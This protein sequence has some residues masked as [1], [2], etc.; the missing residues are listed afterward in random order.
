MKHLGPISG[1]ATYQDKYV[2]TAGYDNLVILWDGITKMPIDRSYHDH[3]ANQCAFSPDGR[4]LVSA[5]SDYTARLW[6]LP[7]MRLQ[8][9]LIG[10]NDDVEM[11]AF[12]SSGSLIATCSRDHTIRVFGL[13]GVIK[14]I[15]CGHKSDVISVTWQHNS[16]YLISS[17]DDG[18]VRKWNTDNGEL[19]ETIDLNGVE[20]DTVVITQ[21]GIIFAGD[22]EGKISVITGTSLIHTPAHSAGIKKLVYNAAK[23]LLVSL[24]YDR[25]L[26]IWSVNSGACLTKVCTAK[27]P[28]II[29]PRSCDF[30]SE[31]K[32]VLGTFGST[33]A[34]YDYG[35]NVWNIEGIEPDISLN[36]VAYVNNKTYAVGDAGIVFCNG[37]AIAKLGSLCNFL[38]PF[39][40]AVLTGGQ[41]GIVFNGIDG[42]IIHQ[43]HSPLNCGTTFVKDGKLHAIIG[44]YTG[45]GLIFHKNR[46]GVIQLIDTIQLHNNATKGVSASDNSIFSVCATGAAAFHC[47]SDFKC[48]MYTENAHDRIANG[49][50]T[51][52]GMRFASISRDLKLRIWDATQVEVFATPHKNSIKCIASSIDAAFIA[53]G[54][55]T[56]TIAI[57]SL[58]QRKWCKVVRPTAAGISSITANTTQNTF[59]ASSY[60]G[61]LYMVSVD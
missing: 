38:L 33:Y 2:A 12:N 31:N 19:I 17:S 61:Q 42:R 28:D 6:E 15:L 27:L 10:H 47:I 5:S 3:L 60:D 23:R 58:V 48:I 34:T 26:I 51:V 22:D 21:C 32:L 13:D 57:F 37:Q 30:F 25:Q 39:D 45:E 9:V 29:W 56:G 54:D 49:C 52:D 8:A 35:I 24:S 11:A 55:Y 16:C 1:I 50:T 44:T 18:T 40:D 4:Y 20:T 46:H 41:L 43:H 14:T 59:L 53:T 7:T 36:A